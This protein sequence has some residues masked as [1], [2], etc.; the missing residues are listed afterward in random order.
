MATTTNNS[1]PIPVAT[2]YVKD[3]WD[4]I[5]D[6]GNGIDTSVGTGLLAWQSWAPTLSNGWLNGNGTWNAVYCQIGKTVHVRARF[7]FGSTTTKGTGALTVS[8]PVNASTS[9]NSLANLSG[10]SY[11]VCAGSGTTVGWWHINATNT[12]ILSVLNTSGT[13]LSRNNVTSTA[14]ATWT[15]NDVIHLALNYEAA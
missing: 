4:A 8:L 2:D 9:P 5:A 14:P 7:D 15:T 13:Y 12:A 1:W 10:L 3:G 11:L 6:L